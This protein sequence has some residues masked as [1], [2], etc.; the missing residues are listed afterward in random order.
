MQWKA[1][2]SCVPRPFE[3]DSN[4]YRSRS[5][6]IAIS[7]GHHPQEIS[8]KHDGNVVARGGVERTVGRE[9]CRLIQK[10]IPS[11]LTVCNL[12]LGVVALLWV[13]AGRASDAAL[14]VVVGMVLDG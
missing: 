6:S 12:A 9:C 8:R 10:A 1:S 13:S 11:L 7:K 3:T 4:G 2:A 5:S 14:M